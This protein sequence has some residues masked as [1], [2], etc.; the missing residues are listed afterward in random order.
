MNVRCRTAGRALAIASV[1]PCIAAAPVA[2]TTGAPGSGGG[3]AAARRSGLL[4]DALSAVRPELIRADIEFLASNEFRGRDTPSNEQRL[5]ARFLR[6]RLQRLGFQ[7]GAKDGWFHTYPLTWRQVQE[8]DTKAWLEAGGQRRELRFAMDWFLGARDLA[9]RTFDGELVWIGKG[10]KADLAAAGNLKGRIALAIDRGDF[11]ESLMEPVAATGASALLLVRD[12]NGSGPRYEEHFVDTV[13]GLRQGSASWP[14]E[15]EPKGRLLRAWLGDGATQALDT[16]TDGREPR[17][18]DALG[19]QFGASIVLHGD[20]KVQCENVCAYWPGIDPELS[21]EVILVSAHYDHIGVDQQGR[22][23]NGADDNG[24]GTTGMLALAEGLATLGPLERSVMLIWVSGEEKGLWGSQAWSD[25]P[26]LPEEGRAVANINIDMIGR[27]AGTSLGVTPTAKH[28][29]YNG[30]TRL[31]ERLASSEGFG[32]LTSADAYYTRS[33]HAMFRRMGIP[34]AFLFA[35]IHA[36]Y[37]QLTDD[38]EKIS[39]DK[40]ARTTRLVLRMIDAMQSPTLLPA[41]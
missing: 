1:L 30:L 27:N 31:A 2:P 33:D 3:V 9:P 38:P 28:K 39:Y 34:V 16:L 24:S 29:E 17:P 14:Q 18:G 15:G 13:A 40:I 41:E 6:N 4:D 22:V 20:G 7:P 11:G 37:H 10:G 19:V 32:A 26:W 25:A 5:A 36:D 12:A 21:R 35:D 8:P 23:F